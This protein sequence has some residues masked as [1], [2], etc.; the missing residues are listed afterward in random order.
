MLL[1]FDLGRENMYIYSLLLKSS[2]YQI[3]L[4]NLQ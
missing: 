3:S 4:I 1:I 2:I